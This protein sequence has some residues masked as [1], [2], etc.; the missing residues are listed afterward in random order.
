MLVTFKMV[1]VYL[2]LGGPLGLIG[3]PYSLLVG[4]VRLLYRVSAQ[5]L[6]PLGLRVAGIRVEVTG[7]EHVPAGVTASTCRTMCR[8]LTRRCCCRCFR[9]SVLCC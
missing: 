7:R 1:L 9:G 3:I 6:V 5:W 4:N 8:T 2:T